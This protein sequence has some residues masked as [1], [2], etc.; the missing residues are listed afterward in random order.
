LRE[1]VILIKKHH[2]HQ[3]SKGYHEVFVPEKIEQPLH[4]KLKEFP[5]KAI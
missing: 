1:Q 5:L 3:K 4:F 2:P